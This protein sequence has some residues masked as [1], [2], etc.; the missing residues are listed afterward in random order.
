MVELFLAIYFFV[1]A[2]C[3]FFDLKPFQNERVEALED[4]KRKK[5]RRVEA[6]SLVVAVMIL[7]AI[8]YV[9]QI[10]EI[11][12]TTVQSLLWFGIPGV[13]VVLLALYVEIFYYKK[14]KEESV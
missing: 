8:Y 11:E 4:R 10:A 5:F 6:L 2:I 14:I 3:D 1:W 13:L 12:M 7:L 9:E